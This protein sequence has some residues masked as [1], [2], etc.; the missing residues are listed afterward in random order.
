MGTEKFEVDKKFVIS[1]QGSQFIKFEGLLD[2]F[3]KNGGK[4]INTELLN[5][6]PVIIKATVDGASGTFTGIGDADEKNCNKLIVNHKIR[7]AETR[8]IGRALRWYLNIGM[9]TVEEMTDI[10]KATTTK[11]TKT[12]KDGETYSCTDCGADISI[13]VKDFSVQHHGKALCMT[14]QKK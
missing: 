5:T 2:G 11:E 14:C 13:K 10:P 4:S 6:E 8:A 7:M 12:G 9:C 1:L 3:H